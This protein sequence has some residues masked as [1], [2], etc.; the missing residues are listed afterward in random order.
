ML[1]EL[2]GR[3]CNSDQSVL[4]GPNTAGGVKKTPVGF[5]EPYE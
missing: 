1:F 3:Y 5:Q 4:L 2:G